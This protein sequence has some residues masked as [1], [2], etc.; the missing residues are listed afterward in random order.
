MSTPALRTEN[1]YFRY[2]IRQDYALHAV[3]VEIFEGEFV[4]LIGQ[5]GCGKTTLLKHFNGLLR[6]TQGKVFIYGQ[7]IADVPTCELAR[8][9]GYVF[10]NPDHQIF[11]DTV[12]EEI[13]FGP[14][15]LGFDQD[16][17]ESATERVLKAVGLEEYVDCPPFALGKGQ[18]QRLA[19]AAVLSMEPKILIIDE[20][21]T[22]QDWSESIQLMELIRNLNLQGHTILISTHNMS[23]VSLYARRV[24]VMANGK[25]W[26]DGTTQ[27]VFSDPDRLREIYIKPPM[28]YQLAHRFCPNVDIS[29]VVTPE[30]LADLL[31]DQ[32]MACRPA[33]ERDLT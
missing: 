5:N 32:I 28:L 33:S 15:N 27:Q 30:D 29:Q 19:V 7:D 2:P 14:K 24:I 3:N 26:M 23:L 22:G 16:H 11:A 21:T 8:Q 25:I 4:A 6:P 31:Y 13:A 9:V 1:L 12:R 17:I 20:P 18:R 10:Q